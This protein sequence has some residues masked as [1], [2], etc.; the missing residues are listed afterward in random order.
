MTNF[1]SHISTKKILQLMY[2]TWKLNVKTLK[3]DPKARCIA[4][5]EFITENLFANIMTR[6][7]NCKYRRVYRDKDYSSA[8]LYSKKDGYIQLK[9]STSWKCSIGPSSFGPKSKYD[10]LYYMTISHKINKGIHAIINIYRIDNITSDLVLNKKGDTFGTQS[11]QGR[12]PRLSLYDHVSKYDIPI[13]K[14][15]T[16][17]IHK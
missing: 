10:I 14:S 2:L 12:R 11:L 1:Y 9:S 7:Y 8:D 13:I 17:L 16:F 6:L 4:Y 3:L 15:K 5:N